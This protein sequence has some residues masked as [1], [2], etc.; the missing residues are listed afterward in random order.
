METILFALWFFL[1]AGVANAVPIVA[2]KIP[3]LST[4]NTPMDFGKKYRGHR[5]FG[6]HKT[7]RGMAAGVLAAIVTVWLQQQIASG[8]N[9][10]FL[11]E[12]SEYLSSPAIL[13]GFLFGFGALM[14]D[15]L[16]SFAK[17]Q[18]NIAPGRAWFPF[19]QIDYII[20]GCLAVSVVVRLQPIDYL[21]IL[22]VWFLMHLVFGYVG[23]LL[24]LKTAPV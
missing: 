18:L 4:W 23:Y 12:N 9:L 8:H 15:A 7:W 3:Y 16:K 1:P 6:S 22:L 5:L 11:N 14:G 20:G 21:A 17:R 10:G 19:D 24:K 2:V 13:L